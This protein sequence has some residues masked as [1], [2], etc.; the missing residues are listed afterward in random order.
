MNDL[1]RKDT[2]GSVAILAAIL[3]SAMCAM[4]AAE[5]QATVEGNPRAMCEVEA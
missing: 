2:I 1:T 5:V 3:V 4:Y